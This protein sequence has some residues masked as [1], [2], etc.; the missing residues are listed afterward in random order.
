MNLLQAA[1]LALVQG[2]TEFLPISSSAHLILVSALTDWEDQGL[3]FDVA[4]HMG[5]LV[6]VVCYFRTDLIEIVR[7]FTRSL[8]GKGH[9]SSSRLGWA[10]ILGTIP[11][12]LAGLIFRDVVAMHLRDPLILAFGL[13]FFGLLLGLA[14]WRRKGDRNEHS[15][16]WKDIMVIGCAQAVALIPGTS[17]SGITM[18][19]GLFMG[20]SRD[21]AARF[22][23][24]LSIPVIFLAGALEARHL[25]NQPEPVQWG[26]IGI[27]TL[28]SGIS[29][30][31]CIH[32][33]LKFIR[34]VGMQPFVVYRLLLG[35]MLVWVYV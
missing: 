24:L 28:L 15:L 30:Y 16:T 10:V 19:A 9:T 8:T 35:L 22:S 18:T 14:D 5:S 21:G 11:V 23:F 6:A 3:T 25:L 4:V 1:I 34:T 20:L 17:R 2:L 31:L 12:G 29:A 32:Y 26:I 13:M 33:F 7:D 27:A